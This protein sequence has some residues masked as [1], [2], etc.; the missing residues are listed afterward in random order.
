MKRQ[1]LRR[2][3]YEYRKLG[4]K[5]SDDSGDEVELYPKK[6]YQ[7][8]PTV[9]KIVEEGDTLQSL[10]IRYGC[11]VAELKRLNHIL[12][13]NEIYAKGVVKVPDRPFSTILAGVHSSGRSSPTGRV[14]LKKSDHLECL[15]NKLK[16]SLLLDIPSTT[17]R[18]CMRR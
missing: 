8:P 10:A 6:L 12:N 16:S 11:S 4:D 15:E 14:A 7:E 9:E 18:T 5:H 2:D 13:D 3:E 1:K 17:R